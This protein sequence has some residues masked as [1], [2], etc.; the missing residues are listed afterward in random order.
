MKRYYFREHRGSLEES[1][2]T[3]RE[4]PT[5][6]ALD[7]VVVRLYTFDKRLNAPTYIA[8]KDGVPI[9]FITEEETD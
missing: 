7:G 4:I 1:L 2:K 8:I 3:R 6:H 9:G 5:L